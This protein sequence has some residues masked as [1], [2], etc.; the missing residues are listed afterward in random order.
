MQQLNIRTEMIWVGPTFKNVD[1]NASKTFPIFERMNLQFRAELYNLLNHTNYSTP[2]NGVQDVQFGQI[3]ARP[4]P[5]A[6]YSS[7]LSWFY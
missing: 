6:R 3:R 1:F 2:D 4:A 7:R 5:D